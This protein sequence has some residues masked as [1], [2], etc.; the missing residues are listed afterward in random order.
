MLYAFRENRLYPDR[1]ISR[2]EY[3]SIIV[4]ALK[5]ATPTTSARS[6]QDVSANHWAHQAITTAKH[7][8]LIKGYPDGMFRPDTPIT[9]AEIA[10][11]TYNAYSSRF[12]KSSINSFLDVSSNYWANGAISSLTRSNILQGYPDSKFRPAAY[13][14]RAEAIAIISRLV[15]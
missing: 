12:V 7:Y 1:Y 6:Y 4:G 8:G 13:T 10:T 15:Y 3:A 5:L 11:L 14:T 2:A 9:R